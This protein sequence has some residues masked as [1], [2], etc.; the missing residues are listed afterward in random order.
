MLGRGERV[1]G[2]LWGLAL[3]FLWG[4]AAAM[5]ESEKTLLS[6]AEE[7]LKKRFNKEEADKR[8]LPSTAAASLPS[9]RIDQLVLPDEM[10]AKMPFTKDKFLIRENPHLVQWEREV[11][12]FE[13]KLSP[14]H[15]HRL[16]AVMI[17]EW[18]T[19]IRI[20][21]IMKAESERVE[22]GHPHTTWRGDLR[23]INKVCEFY[24]GKPYMTWIMGRKV[25]KAYRVRPGYY[26]K[27]HRPMTLT[28]YAEY[29][30]GVLNP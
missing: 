21:D 2:P 6:A 20:V 15:G 25:Q 7:E 19:G 17:Y 16:T 27:Y 3:F 22:P 11:R 10:R 24:F 26:I 12:K 30:E 23:K 14:E 13:R 4:Y 1:S 28:L 9:P 29:A 5:I 18:A 8:R